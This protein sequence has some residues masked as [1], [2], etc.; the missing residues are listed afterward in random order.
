MSERARLSLPDAKALAAPDDFDARLE[1]LG[2]SLAPEVTSKLG[3]FLGVLLSMNERMNL[4]AIVA[5]DAAWERHALDA[6]S[7]VP[8]LASLPSGARV[9]DLGSGGG[10]PAIPLALAR[11][12]LSF[13]L[14]ESTQKK[15]AFLEDVAFELGL[16]NVEVFAERAERVGRAELC[17]RFDAVTARAVANL[18]ALVPLA[19]PFLRPLGSMIFIKGGRADEELAAAKAVM[20]RARV[21]HLGTRTTPTG[22]VVVLEKQPDR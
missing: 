2:I 20:Q 18:S 12:D 21:R 7:L 17:G 11:R 1:A 8:E 9:V 14:V 4:T 3:R 10:V 6:L 19:A 5:P 15:A 22:R 13:S 16:S